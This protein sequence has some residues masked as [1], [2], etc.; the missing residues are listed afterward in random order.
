MSRYK[1]LPV[2][3]ALDTFV[4]NADRA[5]SNYFCDETTDTFYGIDMASSFNQ[6]LCATSLKTSNSWLI[7]IK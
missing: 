6:D 5:G 7:M 2:L 3:V 1:D 4:G